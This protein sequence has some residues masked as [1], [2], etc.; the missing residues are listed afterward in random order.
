MLARNAVLQAIHIGRGT[1]P[2]RAGYS[3]PAEPAANAPAVR[4]NREYG[5]AK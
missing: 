2:I 1:G 5:Q 4:I 3:N